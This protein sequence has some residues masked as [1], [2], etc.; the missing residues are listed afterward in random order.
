[1]CIKLIERFVLRCPLEAKNSLDRILAICTK[2]LKYDP[3]YAGDD[4]DEMMDVDST[5]HDEDE[6]ENASF[7]GD[8]DSITD[9]EYSDDD[10][11]VS[12]KLRKAS[13][14]CLSAI[15][16]NNM[17]RLMDIYH[18]MESVVVERFGEREETVRI[19]VIDAYCNLL[20][21]IKIY[22]MSA[23]ISFTEQY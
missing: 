13:A 1:M 17:G 2:Y 11:D 19:D 20:K 6:D 5:L 15:F 4:Y 7:D 23:D 3:N 21:Q 16:T 8:E 14:S 12:W 9:E 10:D 22:P 18:K